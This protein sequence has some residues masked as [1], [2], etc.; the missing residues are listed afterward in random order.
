MSLLFSKI[1]EVQ[2]AVTKPVKV[3]FTLLLC[4]LGE[5]VSAAEFGPALTLITANDAGSEYGLS[6]QI[7]VLM[8]ILTILPSIVVL[9]TSFTRI[10]IVLSLVRQ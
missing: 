8:S 5:S 3:F 2:P 1:R 6:L 7:L 10:I 9:M 4:A